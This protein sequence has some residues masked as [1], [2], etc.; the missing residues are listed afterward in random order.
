MVV[1]KYLEAHPERLHIESAFLV[2]DALAD[3]FPCSALP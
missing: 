2:I 3:A 1:V